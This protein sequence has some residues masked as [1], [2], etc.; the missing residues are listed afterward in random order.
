MQHE[1]KSVTKSIEKIL[2]D[3]GT[4]AGQFALWVPILYKSQILW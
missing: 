2:H 4:S 1:M 3:P